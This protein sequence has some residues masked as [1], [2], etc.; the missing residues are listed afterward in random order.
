MNDALGVGKADSR[1][2]KFA[3]TVQAL[4]HS[5][6]F[7]L[8]SGSKPAPLSRI[9]ITVSALLFRTQSI[10]ISGCARPL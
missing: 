4:K 10:S 7:P 8:Y 1:A 9:T 5:E 2:F 3:L 6:E